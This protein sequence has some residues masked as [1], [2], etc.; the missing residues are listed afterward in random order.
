MVQQL[1]VHRAALF[2]ALLGAARG[3]GGR[4]GGRELAREEDYEG[5]EAV[6]PRHA[7]HGLNAHAVQ[8]LE[9]VLRQPLA[10]AGC[11][12]LARAQQAR[13]RLSHHS[14]DGFGRHGDGYLRC[15]HQRRERGE[16]RGQ[17]H[18]V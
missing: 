6:A 11:V 12:V 2:E 10:A 8:G 17:E 7:A 15:T 3:G 5:G 1:G 9:H 16:G 4:G 13:H 14:G 18:R